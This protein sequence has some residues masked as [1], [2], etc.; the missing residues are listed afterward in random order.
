[1]LE[2]HH[3]AKGIDLEGM[4]SMVVVYLAGRFLRVENARDGECEVQEGILLREGRGY[5]GCGVG[6][7]LFV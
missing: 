3:G 1:M 2:Q 4:Q 7:G 5:S 6:D